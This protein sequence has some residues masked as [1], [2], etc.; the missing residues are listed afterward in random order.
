[1][2]KT[3]IETHNGR[4]V[5]VRIYPARAAYGA[6]TTRKGGMYGAPTGGNGLGVIPA[7]FSNH[8]NMHNGKVR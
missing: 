7:A 6:Q 1:M 8:V 3:K 5:V 2:V 4:K